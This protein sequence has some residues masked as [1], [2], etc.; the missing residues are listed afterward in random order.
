[1]KSIA[2]NVSRQLRGFA[3]YLP[4]SDIKGP[5]YLNDKVR[6][7]EKSARSQR[8]F[9]QKLRR[10]VDEGAAGPHGEDPGEEDP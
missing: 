3:N 4:N 1:M 6:Q 9:L 2:E 10:I 7:A 8:D 5:R